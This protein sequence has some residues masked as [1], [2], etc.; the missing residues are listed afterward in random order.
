[1]NQFG[2]CEGRSA[3]DQLLL[4]YHDIY[5]SFDKGLTT[6]LIFFDYSKAFDKV[7]HSVMLDKLA[8][9][10][11]NQEL[12]IWIKCFLTNRVMQVRV[13]GSLSSTSQVKSGV[14][15]GSVLGPLLFL[16][17]VNHTVKDL[18]SRYMIFADDTKLYL[19]HQA[20]STDVAVPQLQQDINTLVRTSSSWGLLMNIDK[21]VCM[22][23]A[24]GRSTYANELSPYSI[25]NMPIKFASSHKDLGVLIDVSLKP[26]SH[27]R[28]ISGK[29]NGM[30]TN[31]LTSTL[32]RDKEFLMNIYLSH[33]RPKMEYCSPVWNLEYLGDTRMLERLQRRW[34]RQVWNLRELSY[35][36]RLRSLDLF[37]V[38]GRLLRADLI[39]VWKIFNG[40][41]GISPE[42]IF[43]LNRSTLRGHPLKI[44]VPRTELELTRRFFSTRVISEWNLL[45]ADTVT[46]STLDSFKGLVQRDLGQKLYDFL[47]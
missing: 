47:D 22:R 3:C 44:Y 8:S 4:T 23:F 28:K 40:K 19:S 1:M 14:P 26:H 38:Q 5:S 31:L 45:A 27:V 36:E 11:I 37:S 10:G 17:Y 25:G 46:A 9:I 18:H 16:I 30:I 35:A 24:R 32:C 15:Q 20:N 43:T 7:C 39:L 41:C 12:I 29:C 21:C 33:I 42:Q 6:D 34:T 2:F 13:A